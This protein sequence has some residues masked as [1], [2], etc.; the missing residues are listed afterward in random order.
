MSEE[1]N[2]N[3]IGSGETLSPP[4]GHIW[5]LVAICMGIWAIPALFAFRE[6]ALSA[7]AFWILELGWLLVWTG[8]FATTALDLRLELTALGITQ[9]RW[10]R[11]VII[12][13]RDATA[14]RRGRRITVSGGGERIHINPLL[15]RSGA[16]LYEFLETHLADRGEQL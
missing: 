7:I 10:F 16:K 8:V 12:P 15:F 3:S 5:I 6:L 14:I 2:Q 9:H 4:K 11:D 1:R 13:W